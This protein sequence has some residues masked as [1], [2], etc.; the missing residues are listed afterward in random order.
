MFQVADDRGLFSPLRVPIVHH[1]VS[2][3]VDDLVIS[4]TPM[5][6]D[7][8]LLCAILQT[9]TGASGL[10]T[11]VS[12]CQATPIRCTVEQIALSQQHMPCQLVHFPYKYLGVHLSICVLKKVDFQPLV[13]AVVV[14]VAPSI[15]KG[16]NKLR[17]F[18]EGPP[19]V[20]CKVHDVDQVYPII[21]GGPCRHC[22]SR[23]PWYHQRD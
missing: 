7:I 9:F 22:G 11:N 23:G 10:Q 12:K 21:H 1:Q 17:R 4:I 15:I 13:D 6:V 20:S 18:M 3:Y 14:H 19:D 2:L 16:I 8:A 5:E